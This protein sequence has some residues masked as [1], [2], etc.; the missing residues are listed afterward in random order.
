MF[1]NTFFARSNGLLSRAL[2]FSLLFL[3]VAAVIP[4]LGGFQKV[5]A[6]DAGDDQMAIFPDSHESAPG[7]YSQPDEIYPSA[8]HRENLMRSNVQKISAEFPGRRFPQSP[9][10]QSE[11]LD[12]NKP[13]TGI[14]LSSG[15][16]F[17]IPSRFTGGSQPG[18]IEPRSLMGGITIDLIYDVVMGQ[19]GPGETVSVTV[20]SDGYGMTV[21]D[22][23]G[24]FWTPIWHNTLGLKLQ[25]NCET[26]IS[27]IVG[28]DPAI[29]IVPPCIQGGIDVLNDS[30][31][32][33]IWDDTGGTFV[34]FQRGNFDPSMDPETKH[35]NPK[36][37]GNGEV[38]N[39]WTDSSGFFNFDFSDTW[40]LG[41]ESF[42]SVDCDIDGV[43][44][45]SYIYPDTSV[46]MVQQYNIIAGYAFVGQEI[47]ATVYDGIGTVKWSD[48]TNAYGPHGFYTFS[49]APIAPGDTVEVELTGGAT[50]TTSVIALEDLNFDSNSDMLIGTAPDGETVRVSLWQNANSGSFYKEDKTTATTGDQFTID[51]YHFDQIDLQAKDEVLVVVPDSNGNQV[52]VVSGPPFVSASISLDSNL[53]CVYG[54]LDE[55]NLPIFVSL[56]KGG[57]EVYTR[58]T[59]WYSDAGNKFD[60]CFTIRDSGDNMINFDPGDMV[61]LRSD[62]L[63]KWSGSVDVVDFSW[64]GVSIN[65][66][67]SGETADGELEVTVAKW[68]GGRYP[69][70]GTET[71]QTSVSSSSF[72]VDFSFYFDIRDGIMI[73]FAH[74]DPVT[75]YGIET[76]PWSY[77]PTLPYLE[78]ALPYGVSGMVGSPGE[79]VTASLYNGPTLLA[80]TSDDRNDDPYGFWLDDFQG[81]LLEPGYRVEVSSSGGWTADMIVPELSINGEV[82]NDMVSAQGPP[83]LLLL[84]VYDYITYLTNFVPGPNA[85]L[86][87]NFQGWDLQP[88]D[89][90]AVTYQAVDGNRARLQN[91][92]NEVSEVNFWFN[93]GIDDWMWGSAKPG[94]TVTAER[95]SITLFTSYADPAC[96]GCWNIDEP[97]ELNPG[98]IITVTAGDGILPVVI[99][100]PDPL[101]AYAD[102]STDEVW[103]QI[104]HLDTEI[105]D[106]NGNWEGGYQ[107][108]YT[109]SSGYYSAIYTD[110][111]YGADGYVHYYTMAYWADINFNQY[112]RTPDLL[113]DVNYGHD[114]IEGSYPPG[115]D[116][117]LTVTESDKITVKATASMTTTDIPWWGGGTGFSTS[118]EGVYWDP[119]QPDIQVGDWVLGEV[120]VDTTTYDAEV[121]V[122]TITG[123]VDV[124][125]DSLTGTIK[126]SWLPQDVEIQ[127]TCHPWGGP[128][129]VEQKFDSILPNG[130]D[131]YHCEW[132]PIS[133]WDVEPY[134]DIGVSYQVSEGHTIYNAF[135]AYSDEL[136][137]RIHKDHEWIEGDYEPGHNIHLTV[138]DDLMAEKAHITVPTGLIEDWSGRSGFATYFHDEAWV[139]TQPNIEQGD[140]I[141]GE[142]DDGSQYWADVEVGTI[143][144]TP[145]V[146]GDSISGTV[147]ADWLLPG[148][149]DVVCSIWEEGGIE[150]LTTAVPDGLDTYTCI[151]DDENA[152]DIVP[153]TNL[154]VSYL[155]LDGHQVYGDFSPPAPYLL[156]EK[157]F[158]GG[159][160]PGVGGNAA[161]YVQYQNQG[162]LAAAEVTITDTLEGMNYLSDTSGF[163]ADVVGNQVTWNLGTVESSEDWIGFVVF[164]EV[165]ATVGQTVSNTAQISTTTSFDQ[166]DPGEKIG[167][168][169]GT[170]IAN[171][172]HLNVGKDT[173]TENPAPGQDFIYQINVCNNGSTSSS[174]LNLIETM[175]SG[176][177]F[178]NWWSWDVGWYVINQTDEILELGH[179]CIS[180][181]T[182]SEVF[183]QVTVD[184]LANPGDELINHVEI[185]A[186]N[187]LSVGDDVAEL[188]HQVGEPYTDLAIWQ[189]WHN[190][191]LTPGSQYHY[192]ITYKNEGNV[193]ITNSVDITATLPENVTFVESDL[194]PDTVTDNI[195]TWQIAGGMIPGVQGTIDVTVAIDSDAI[196]GTQLNHLA[197]IELQTGEENSGN[198]YSTFSEKVQ[199]AGPN[200]RLEKW[201]E[202]HGDDTDYYAWYDLRVENIGDE[203][204]ND[205]VI[206]DTFPAGMAL[207]DGPHTDF[208]EDWD[209][210]VYTEVFTCTLSRLEPG[211]SMS[212]YFELAPALMDPGLVYTNT[213]EVIP[214][215]GDTNPGD[216]F[217]TF[218][219][220]S[221]P[222]MKIEK[223]LIEGDFIPGGEVTYLLRFG[224]AFSDG[225]WWGNPWWWGM[226]GNAII[227]D[228][229]PEGMNY[230]SAYEHWCGEE[231]WWEYDPAIV[232]QDLIWT[233]DPLDY[234]DCFEILLTVE[235][236][237]VDDANPLINEAMIESDQPLVDVDPFPENNVSIY[238]P[239]LIIENN[240]YI[241]LILR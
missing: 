176:T 73:D 26:P 70:L 119:E 211:W 133:E 40:D 186:D 158:I 212:L 206:T 159:G 150:I 92:L 185:S 17:P 98:E 164:A 226:Q 94:T 95:D 213:A 101:T 79:T 80:E 106:V 100:I 93:P 120:V 111:P 146:A 3:V 104:D 42:F 137:M 124:T 2:S 116:V 154:M 165:T 235:I 140:V 76:N 189:G 46:F 234:Y 142:V 117:T 66:V 47:T 51:F 71:M 175:P 72:S 13:Y 227:T 129:N 131:E 229:L 30:V 87:T 240:I 53:D 45:R 160:S 128:E 223:T 35:I 221:G 99:Q 24:Y 139:P 220:F 163:T 155:E 55:P 193:T 12:S 217:S 8:I 130:I 233:H 38:L 75:G 63:L 52:Q 118:L 122:G 152:Y 230:V 89:F 171:D 187:D 170:V 192:G 179:E 238:D 7:S 77:R 153:G 184:P 125:A 109:D 144:G 143:T 224:N 138:Y 114:W 19:V 162:G 21:A 10:P 141:H 32:G 173:W 112:F 181:W 48:I 28:S 84:E 148:P 168:W 20:G 97:V 214:L 33:R 222:D 113:L 56:D 41:A 147:D 239:G 156:I 86:D 68:Q 228:T 136:I 102:S 23:L 174:T 96:D 15:Q 180:G 11:W 132:D 18:V 218:V 14:D 108:I 182:C 157:W 54:R 183:V 22:N 85:L 65:D 209:C 207:R 167:Y 197:E 110:I 103:G 59:E 200:L 204:V 67:I 49:E 237:D 16:D 208:W 123:D 134:Q 105:V 225:D 58:D 198:N 29:E 81:N 172:T 25:I 64:E 232:D 6:R 39:V 83:G 115:Y 191:S 194:A 9:V 177:D 50:L 36:P 90:V 44:V 57:G 82:S 88:S 202:W 135:F 1:Q 231:E 161:F 60:V 74:F 27:I 151:F 126:A 195:V 210:D 127:V 219:L 145:D 203:T 215:E 196:P 121:R 205:V 166:G 31:L 69:L 149:V 62:D 236:G 5:D 34:A 43:W 241:P 107:E 37:A 178:G 188:Q 61:T 190:G 199:A 78:L 4:S 216:N 201:G 91:Q 169:E